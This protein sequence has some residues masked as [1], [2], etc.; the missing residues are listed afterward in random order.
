MSLGAHTL[1][2]LRSK[3]EFERVSSGG[4][5]FQSTNVGLIVLA[6]DIGSPR[7]GFTIPRH[8]V[9]SAVRRNRLKRV[10][11]EHLGEMLAPEVGGYDV[12]VRV[13]LD[14]GPGEYKQLGSELQH[15]LEKSGLMNRRDI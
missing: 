14:P 9:K 15:L 10:L 5:R 2:R 7:V 11:R 12:V 13:L 3:P 8:T 4:R 1:G 6:N